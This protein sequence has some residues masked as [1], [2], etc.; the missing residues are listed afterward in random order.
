MKYYLDT[1]IWRDYYENRSDKLRPLGEWAFEFLSQALEKE[2]TILYSDMIVTELAKYYSEKEIF[3]IFSIIAKNGSILR[4][5]IS[6]KQEYEARKLCQE[7]NIAFGDALHAVLA[8]DNDAIVITRD[9]HFL[10]LHS[11]VVCKKPEELL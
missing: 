5:L 4:A 3:S 11:I 8:R 1:C 2:C 9:K 6:S 7:H 10:S